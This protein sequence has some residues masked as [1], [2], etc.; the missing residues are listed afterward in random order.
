MVGALS[1]EHG[2][3]PMASTHLRARVSRHTSVGQLMSRTVFCLNVDT[4]LED[5]TRRLLEQ[6]FSAAPVLDSVG[7]PIGII[8][9]AD[10]LEAWSSASEDASAM[11]VGDLM[12]PYLTTIPEETPLFVAMNLFQHEGTHRLIVTNAAHQMVG[13]ITELDMMTWLAQ[14][15]GFCRGSNSEVEL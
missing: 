15:S 3:A 12:I 4:S 9:K 8:S 1:L 7:K 14:L 13:I 11:V 6:G 10:L 5:A 2:Y